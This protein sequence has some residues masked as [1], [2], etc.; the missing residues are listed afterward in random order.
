MKVSLWI[1]GFA[2][3]TLAACSTPAPTTTTTTTTTVATPPPPVVV[4]QPANTSP[5]PANCGTPS[6]PRTCPPLPRVPLAK[7]PGPR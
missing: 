7:Y 3:L 6:E 2:T 5:D 1:A 4:N